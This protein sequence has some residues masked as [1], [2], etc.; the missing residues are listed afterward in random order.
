MADAQ[1]GCQGSA[2]PRSGAGIMGTR[3]DEKGRFAFHVPPGEQFVY[4][5]DDV[6]S[7]RMSRRVVVVPEQGEVIP[8]VLLQPATG[9]QPCPASPGG[10]GRRAGLAVAP[11]VRPAPGCCS[12]PHRVAPC[13]DLA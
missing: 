5:I 10:V 8:L 2:V 1:V 3:T 12:S 4:L 9:V 6:S 11:D 13:R 7:S